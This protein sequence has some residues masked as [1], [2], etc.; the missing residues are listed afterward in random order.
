MLSL[1]DVVNKTSLSRST[2]ARLE[3]QGD[4]PKRIKI[5]TR[6]ICWLENDIEAFINRKA[7]GVNDEN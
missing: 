2:I 3:D 1:R 5:S 4:F 6:R 7:E